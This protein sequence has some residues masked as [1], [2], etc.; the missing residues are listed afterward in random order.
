MPCRELNPR[1]HAGAAAWTFCIV[2]IV[3]YV[4][5]GRGFNKV[6]GNVNNS[7]GAA[8]PALSPLLLKAMY[9]TLCPHMFSTMPMTHGILEAVKGKQEV[10]ASGWALFGGL[11]T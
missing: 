2:I 4:T 8:T 3:I 10:W 5:N 6:K 7:I 11:V 9:F 1:E